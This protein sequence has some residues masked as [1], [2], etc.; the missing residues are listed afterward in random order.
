MDG[1]EVYMLDKGEYLQVSS[2]CFA[3]P[4]NY[5]SVVIDHFSRV[6][7]SACRGTQCHV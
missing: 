2:C 4:I 6:I 7:R 3:Y 1:R 5:V